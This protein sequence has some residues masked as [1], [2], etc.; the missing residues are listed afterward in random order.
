M[1]DI[2]KVNKVY[3]DGTQAL[4]SI[5]L[6]FRKGMVGLLGPNGAGKSTLMRTI[7]CLQ[8]PDSGK[9]KL[10]GTDIVHKP[11]LMRQTLG[12]LPQYFGVYPHM[13]CLALLRHIATLKGLSKAQQQ[14]QI[15][16]LLELTNLSHAANKKV[17]VFSGGMRQRFGI[18]Q[19]LLGDPKVVI[20][21]EPTAGLDPMEREKLHELLV[22]ISADKLILLSTHIV[23]DVENL[24]QNVTLMFDGSI[25]ASGAIPDLLLPLKD[26]IWRIKRKDALSLPAHHV[27]LSRQFTHG[28]SEWRVL[29]DDIPC[30]FA[31]PSLPTLQ[32]LYFSHIKQK[33]LC[34]AIA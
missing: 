13:S 22:T 3:S 24:C 4:N 29:A 2:S 27:V 7:A 20:M 16:D 1:I 8:K 30:D 17:S 15:P 9:I 34:D 10:N 5:S 14:K 12:Y 28:Q 25:A 11:E 6:S 33:D 19:A 32:D 26:R 18:A 23:E 31:E 21:D